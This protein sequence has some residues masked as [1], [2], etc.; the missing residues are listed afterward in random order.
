MSRSVFFRSCIFSRPV[1]SRPRRYEAENEQWCITCVKVYSTSWSSQRHSQKGISCYNCRGQNSVLSLYRVQWLNGARS[2]WVHYQRTS[3]LQGACSAKYTPAITLIF[4]HT[5]GCFFQNVN[6][7]SFS[8]LLS[9]KS[10]TDLQLS[11]EE[12]RFPHARST[13]PVDDCGSATCMTSSIFSFLTNIICRGVYPYL[14]LATNAPR[15][16]FFFG[17]GFY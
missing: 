13:S 17:G 7:D 16:I 8:S 2:W 14:P 11:H 4:G 1:T 12:W 6:G 15:T 9:R 10:E 5:S 3:L